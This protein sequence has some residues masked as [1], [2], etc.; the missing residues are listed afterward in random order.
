MRRCKGEYYNT[1][2]NTVEK[3]SVGKFHCWGIS[4][5]ESR[6]GNIVMFSIGIIELKDG[7]IVKV[8][9]EDLIFIDGIWS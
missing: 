6:Q 9:P 8:P 3:F 4:Y 7:T 5:K 2:T 1:T